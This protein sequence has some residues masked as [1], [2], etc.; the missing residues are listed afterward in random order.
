MHLC[1]N[2]PVDDGLLASQGTLSMPIQSTLAL[3]IGPYRTLA[4]LRL[5]HEDD[6][7]VVLCGGFVVSG[8]APAA[9]SGTTS[10]DSVGASRR[11]PMVLGQSVPFQSARDFG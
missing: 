11:E 4:R 1:L 2:G 9:V 6:L 10:G 7:L 3:G 5:D 8:R